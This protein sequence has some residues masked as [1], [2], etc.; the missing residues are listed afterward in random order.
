MPDPATLTDHTRL[1][2]DEWPYSPK[3]Q[4]FATFLGLPADKD[5]KGINWQHDKKTA[6]KIEQIYAW[7]K[8]RSKSDDPVDVMIAVKQ[9][10]RDLGVTFR[11]KPLVDHLWGWARL[12][13][14]S[15][16]LEEKQEGIEKE[17]SLYQESL[18]K[19]E[20]GS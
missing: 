10:T 5:S 3:F 9:L 15:I 4:E 17:K 18:E 20:D 1:S 16:R 14:K 2:T 12:D 6:D 19:E 11:G 13:T 8:A 7:G